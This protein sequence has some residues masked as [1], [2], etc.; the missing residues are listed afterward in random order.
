[1][2]ESKIILIVCSGN[3]E[4]SVI[5]ERC[6]NRTL[7]TRGL[8]S[9]FVA[10]SRGLQTTSPPVG[11]NLRDYEDEWLASCPI[12]QEIGIDISDA[13][14]TPVDLSVAEKASLIL[15]MDE[16]VLVKKPNSLV[17]QFP[18]HG[19]KMRLFMELAGNTENVPDPY[20]RKNQETHRRV[21][22]LIHSVSAER[23]DA[24]LNYVKLFQKRS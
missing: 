11:K 18:A 8:D 23:L 21:I 17:K 1:M 16:G 12:L 9:E 2:A 15:V 7:K 10:I 24:L 20:G 4:R 19:Y 6:I 14:S 3:I 13:V 22:E 5:A